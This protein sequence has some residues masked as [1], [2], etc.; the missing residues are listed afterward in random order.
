MILNVSEEQKK[1]IESQGHIEFCPI[2]GRKL[3]E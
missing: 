2:C 3:V 1:I